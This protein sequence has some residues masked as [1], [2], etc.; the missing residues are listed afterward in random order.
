MEAQRNVQGSRVGVALVTVVILAALVGLVSSAA[1]AS[2]NPA[3]NLEIPAQEA[4]GD[5]PERLFDGDRVVP[6]DLGAVEAEEAEQEQW[7]ESPAAEEEREVSRDAYADLSPAAS[8]ALLQ[9]A[10]SGQLA[11]LNDDPARFL[12]DAQLI[13]P[14]EETAAAVK[15]DGDYSLMDA[16][17][18]VRA[19]EEDG[20]LAKVDLSLASTSE[21]FEPVNG[22]VDVTLP[23][24]ADEAT[25]VGEA[26]FGIAQSDAAP[27]AARRFGDKNLFYSDV[28]PDTDL[29]VAPTA[30]GVEL[31][32]LLRSEAS[33]EELRFAIE[34]PAGAVL[35]ADGGGGAEVIRD[36]ETLTRIA[37][38]VASDAQGTEV[39][40]ELSVE[41]AGVVLHADHQDGDFAYPILVDP[42]VEDWANNP[43]NWYLTNAKW[44][45]LSN[46][47]WK[48][49][50]NNSQIK[51][52]TCCWE[53][54]HA[55]LMI[56]SEK[57]VFYGAKQ[58]GQWSYSTANS[59]T[60]INHAC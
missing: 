28:L 44:D 59:K 38:P 33:P 3:V 29:L 30:G 39:P 45:A 48:Y 11:T 10:F 47:A 25:Q 19:E 46:G 24:A 57:N 35:R 42:I 21:G 1:G 5:D 18:P 49:A 50:S 8:E 7:L 51:G 12:S 41:G 26:G 34:V 54:S 13:R 53:G 37:T 32:D 20:D 22:L 43:N 55:G 52:W 58:F 17:I 56:S 4:S 23:S 60:Y 9:N 31:F 15:N 40:V 6:V 14:L 36:G 2:D 27:S 16:G